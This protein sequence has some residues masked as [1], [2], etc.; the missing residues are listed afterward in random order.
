LPKKPL[1]VLRLRAP[2]KVNLT[3]EVLRRRSDGY[4]EVATILQAVG[5]WDVL[6][7]EVAPGLTV[8]CDVAGLNGP[9]NLVMRAAELLQAE[10]HTTQGAALRLTKRIPVA[11]GLGGGS[12]DAAAALV[13]LDRLWGLHLPG[14]RLSEMAASLGSDVP[15]FLSGGTALATGRGERI[16]TLPALTKAYLV[17]LAPPLNLPR[18]TATLY[19]A[20]APA[21]FHD[22]A[23][24]GRVASLLER[25]EQVRPEG[26]LNTF[27]RVA[28][29]VFPDLARFTEMMRSA[30]AD[31]VHLAGSGPVLF[32]MVKERTVGREMALRL[33][34]EGVEA[35]C[36]PTVSGG[37]EVAAVHREAHLAEQ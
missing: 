9:D 36:V 2:A 3:L 30:G 18:K 12:A 33:R 37:V 23:A 25:G 32:C 26:F 1:N 29:R 4:H 11:G 35:W 15:F 14:G 34:N 27:E 17:L 20:L 13:G 22:G 5:L 24:S 16:A 8:G 19:G 7:L 31:W 28:Y 6:E 10:A 21:D